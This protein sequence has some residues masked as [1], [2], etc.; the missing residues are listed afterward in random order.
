[1]SSNE[2]SGLGVAVILWRRRWLAIGVA[3]LIVA[4][5]LPWGLERSRSREIL[6][7]IPRIDRGLVASAVEIT[8]EVRMAIAPALGCSPAEAASFGVE[9]SGGLARLTQSI[10]S[11]ADDARVAEL[12]ERLRQ[13]ATR[14]DE[15]LSIRLARAIERLDVE[16]LAFEAQLQSLR[17]APAEFVESGDAPAAYAKLVGSRASAEPGGIVDGVRD[18]RAS[19]R[20]ARLLAIGG[21]AVL[22]GVLT[23]LGADM[24]LAARSIARSSSA[25]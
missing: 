22:A 17:E 20:M 2:Q 9:E 19:G 21:L 14:L 4:V 25:S 3:V 1:M 10:P 11:D 23:A 16:I 18:A 7:R 8:A 12:D 13:V 5:T 24:L 15:V 6:V